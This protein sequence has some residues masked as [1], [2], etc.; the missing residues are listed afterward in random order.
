[1]HP[2]IYIG[3]LLICN[4]PIVQ[5]KELIKTCP[6][7]SCQL[8]GEESESIFCQDCGAKIG[9]AHR[10]TSRSKVDTFEL[11]DSIKEVFVCIELRDDKEH[12]NKNYLI[13]NKKLKC[14]NRNTTFYPNDAEF[15]QKLDLI[16]LDETQAMESELKAEIE[17]IKKAYGAANV[18]SSWGMVNQII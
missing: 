8:H 2:K 10:M 12:I 15:Y 5:M 7:L 13:L 16:Q 3:P 17:T 1:M 11:M 18:S 9:N 6:N 4:N 14:I